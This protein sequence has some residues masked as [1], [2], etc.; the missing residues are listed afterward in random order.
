MPFE[1]VA[2]RIL[3][4]RVSAFLDFW[5]GAPHEPE[6]FH[7]KQ[8]WFRGTPEFDDA[9]RAKFAADHDRAIAGEHAAWEAEPLSSWRW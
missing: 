5:F 8:I 2:R 9:V 6:C 3:P 7:H 1:P 4:E